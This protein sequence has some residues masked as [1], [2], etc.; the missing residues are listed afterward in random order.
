MVLAENK[1]CQINLGVP[2]SIQLIQKI[3]IVCNKKFKI[4]RVERKTG[5][6]LRERDL[7]KKKSYV[8]YTNDKE[9]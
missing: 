4:L 2:I 6:Q 5:K 7:Q 3:D 8:Y 9:Y 1:R